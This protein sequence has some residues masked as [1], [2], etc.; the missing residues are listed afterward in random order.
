MG[1]CGGSKPSAK[2]GQQVNGP[3]QPQAIARPKSSVS[4]EKQPAQ[5]QAEAQ[6]PSTPRQAPSKPLLEAKQE[7]APPNSARYT[8][9]QSEKIEILEKLA[10]PAGIET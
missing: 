9:E 8:R 3:V 7:A 2:G 10:V 6:Q 5:A 4:S 1:N